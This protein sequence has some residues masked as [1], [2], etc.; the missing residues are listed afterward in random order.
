MTGNSYNNQAPQSVRRATLLNDHRVHKNCYHSHT[1]SDEGGRY[2][3]PDQPR[4][5]VVGSTPAPRYPAGPDWS[6]DLTGAEPPL[7]V[8]INEM[9]PVGEVFEIQRS[10]AEVCDGTDLPPSMPEPTLP[11]GAETPVGKSAAERRDRRR[12]L[13]KHK[14]G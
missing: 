5:H 13:P 7:G 10:L 2:D 12:R 6:A 3:G 4:R 8:P 14:T 11:G 9:A 1:H